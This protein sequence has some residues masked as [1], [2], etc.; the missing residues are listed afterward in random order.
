MEAVDLEHAVGEQ[1]KI[2]DH[3]VGGEMGKAQD[4]KCNKTSESGGGNQRSG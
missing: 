3:N 4:S 1:V 2:C